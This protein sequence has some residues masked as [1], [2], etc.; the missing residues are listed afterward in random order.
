MK[1]INIEKEQENFIK[2]IENRKS[3][4]LSM[5]DDE[6][7]PFISNAAFV[8]YGEAFYIYISSIADHFNFINNS[9]VINLML[10]ADE[11]ETHNHFATERAR[12]KC[13]PTNLGNEGHDEIFAEFE[14]VHGDKL[15]S[16]LRTLDFSLFALT[17]KEGRY[18]VGFGKAFNVTISGTLFEHVVIDKKKE[19]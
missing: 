12:F 3:C 10:V 14:K 13:K 4:V 17:P 18:V 19:Q 5:I 9:E 16:L 15:M 1:P 2:F 11:N 6:G 8:K 7:Q